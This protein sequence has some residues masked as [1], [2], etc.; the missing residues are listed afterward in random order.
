MADMWWIWVVGGLVLAGLEVLVP[1]YVFLG[2]AIGAVT[3]GLMLW[4]GG[5]FGFLVGGSLPWLLLV[6]AVISGLAWFGLRQWLGVRK[7]QVKRW[8]KDINEG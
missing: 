8:N 4:A 2:F 3:T 7:G 1:G 5:P 6:F